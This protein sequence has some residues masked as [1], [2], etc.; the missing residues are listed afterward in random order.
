V[1]SHW[2]ADNVDDLSNEEAFV[3]GFL[4][5]IGKLIISTF[6]PDEYDAIFANFKK[7]H[8]PLQAELKQ[9]GMYHTD[10]GFYVG[11][12]WDFP[13]LLLTVIRDHHSHV[14]SKRRTVLDIVYFANNL[15]NLTDLKSG[16]I[17]DKRNQVLSIAKKY[18]RIDEETLDTF[19]LNLHTSIEDTA[20]ELDIPLTGDFDESRFIEEPGEKSDVQKA[21]EKEQEELQK[22]KLALQRERELSN[23]LMQAYYNMDKIEDILLAL[24]EGMFRE[25]NIEMV[26]IFNVNHNDGLLEGGIGFGI[27]W[28]EKIKRFKYDIRKTRNAFTNS[29]HEKENQQILDTTHKAYSRYVDPEFLKVFNITQFSTFPFKVWGEVEAVIVTA[30]SGDEPMI[31]DELLQ[32]VNGLSFQA[33]MAVERITPK[34]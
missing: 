23:N 7:G 2:L 27:D 33:G 25:L 26:F 29:I 10:V 11:K 14:L 30:F 21:I 18:F 15:I 34:K 20:E 31:S 22:K 32:V 24:A 17:I 3:A 16:E 8:T 6:T 1:T 9:I 28:Q 5:D 4:H 12:K 19:L 13:G